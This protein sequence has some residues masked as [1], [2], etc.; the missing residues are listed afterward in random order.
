MRK[1]FLG[2]LL[3]IIGLGTWRIYEAKTPPPAKP[4]IQEVKSGEVELKI[5]YEEDR[6][7]QFSGV[8][9]K[10]GVTALDVLQKLGKENNFEVTVEETSFGPFIKGIGKKQGDKEHFWA[11]WVNGRMS[12]VGAGEYLI[13]FDDKIEFKYTK[14]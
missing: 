5:A 14:M 9:I 4:V 7:E 2:V 13:K 1:I 12:E 3:L 11:F 8:K 10:E 6:A